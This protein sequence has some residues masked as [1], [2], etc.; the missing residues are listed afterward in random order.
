MIKND[1]FPNA[2][3]EVYVILNNMSKKDFHNHF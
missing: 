3:K 1:N 2:Y